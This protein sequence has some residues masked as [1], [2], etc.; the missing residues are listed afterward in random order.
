MTMNTKTEKLHAK[1]R[2]M[3]A[4]A[5]RTEGNE[6]EAAVAARMVEKLMRKH[7]LSIGDVTPEQ[8]KSDILGSEWDK[9]KWTA[10]RCPAWVQG[11]AISISGVFD[12][13]VTFSVASHND[14]HVHAYQVNL[15][16]VGTELDVQVSLQLFSYLYSTI[17][18]LTDKYFKENPSPK[19]KARTY[20][21]SFRSGMGHRLSERLKELKAEREKEFAQTGTTLIVVKQDAIA[22]YLGVELKYGT[23]KRKSS[24]NGEAYSAGCSAANSVGLNTQLT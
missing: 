13:F 9:M 21:N 6:E 22:E 10:N 24:L 14:K 18:R 5:E 3:M 4:M 12:T 19:G 8:I 11:I 2:K 20:K 15:R 1:I 17:I 7:N 16:F 23:S